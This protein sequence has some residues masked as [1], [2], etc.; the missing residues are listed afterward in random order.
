MEQLKRHTIEE[1]EQ[2]TDEVFDQYND[3]LCDLCFKLGID[4]GAHI[5]PFGCPIAMEQ[6]I[7]EL[8]DNIK[9]PRKR[10]G[11]SLQQMPNSS[12]NVIWKANAPIEKCRRA[13]IDIIKSYI[14]TGTLK[15]NKTLKHSSDFVDEPYQFREI[16]SMH[17]ECETEYLCVDLNDDYFNANDWISLDDLNLN[18]LFIIVDQIQH[19]KALLSTGSEL[20]TTKAIESIIL[21]SGLVENL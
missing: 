1:F 8:I 2:M 3:A 12:Q 19:N 4:V 18:L 13:L 17:F 9:K 5:S 15:L 20:Y 21:D 11:K 14:G 10:Q 7:L 16:Q 6:S